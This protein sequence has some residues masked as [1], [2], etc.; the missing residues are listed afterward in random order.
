MSDIQKPLA[1]LLSSSSSSSSP[2]SSEDARKELY[3]KIYQSLKNVSDNIYKFLHMIT[4]ED[5]KS[6]AIYMTIS[7]PL[8]PLIIEKLLAS[9]SFA[10]IESEYCNEIELM[11][12][13]DREQ[14]YCSKCITN[15][16]EV[17]EKIS[18]LYETKPTNEKLL[19]IS[20]I[21]TLILDDLKKWS[22]LCSSDDDV[23]KKSI[24]F[25]CLVV[26]GEGGEG[27][28]GGED[29]DTSIEK[30]IINLKQ[31]REYAIIENKEWDNIK[32]LSNT[33]KGMYFMNKSFETLLTSVTSFTPAFTS[34]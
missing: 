20:E 30:F 10:K 5:I 3:N 23:R 16:P 18:S 9:L 11:S 33:E 22:E 27:G 12:E 13:A 34:N 2:L 8:L 7:T 32:N 14:L 25:N 19:M 4:V 31:C 6:G 21:I 15:T 28:E 24:S 17:H 26:D 1:S 29:D